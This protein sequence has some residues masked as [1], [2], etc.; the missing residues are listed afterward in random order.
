VVNWIEMI[1]GNT[2]WC[3]F[4]HALLKHHHLL[5][6]LLLAKWHWAQ[7]FSEF[8]GFAQSKSFRLCSIVI[9]LDRKYISLSLP[10]RNTGERFYYLISCQEYW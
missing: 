3:D 2:K 10:C 7:I 4:I 8:F 6:I 1:R 9:Q 5:W